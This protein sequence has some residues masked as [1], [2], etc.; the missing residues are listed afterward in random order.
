MEEL[1]SD[2]LCGK[3]KYS[4]FFDTVEKCKTTANGTATLGLVSVKAYALNS[5]KTFVYYKDVNEGNL[6]NDKILWDYKTTY[7]AFIKPANAEITTILRDSFKSSYDQQLNLKVVY[8]V[9][10]TI[11]ANF[12]FVVLCYP[13]MESLISFIMHTRL[14]LSII[15]VEAI[16][17]LRN[18]ENLVVKHLKR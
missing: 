4:S 1:F 8:L 15:P 17:T 6:I 3:E 10:F 14:M 2:S 16:V 9:V 11:C 13:F 18:F 5:L 12:L 7:D